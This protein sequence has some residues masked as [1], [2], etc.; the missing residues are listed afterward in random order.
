MITRKKSTNYRQL[1]QA[2]GGSNQK[3]VFEAIQLSLRKAR[4]SQATE[5]ERGALAERGGGHMGG[6]MIYDYIMI[7]IMILIMIKGARMTLR[8]TG[9][10]RFDVMM[11]L[12]MA[13][14]KCKPIVA[15]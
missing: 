7:A 1:S 5:A 3:L 11:L 13:N 2:L 15:Q 6:T 4:P 10:L 9:K 14:L 12:M 8:S